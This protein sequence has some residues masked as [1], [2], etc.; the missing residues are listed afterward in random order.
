MTAGGS[1]F[2]LGAADTNNVVQAQGQTIAL[3][4]GSFSTLTFLGTA[5]NGAQPAQ[6]FLVNH[7]D[8]S[9]DVF[10]VDMSD[11]QNPQGYADESRAAALGYD[12]YLDGSSPGVPNYLYQYSLGLNNQKTVSSITLPNNPNVMLLA[13]DLLNLNQATAFQLALQTKFTTDIAVQA[14][15]APDNYWPQARFGWVRDGSGFLMRDPGN[16]ANVEWVPLSVPVS[17][18]P[19]TFTRITG[20]VHLLNNH[21]LLNDGPNIP[22]P[23]SDGLPRSENYKISEWI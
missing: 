12:D 3:P 16:A 10:T 23:E 13:M 2:A 21:W 1:V 22:G 20:I 11:W 9:S 18:N 14:E 4:A 8:G 6:T 19:L 17:L 5:V 15:D 7:T